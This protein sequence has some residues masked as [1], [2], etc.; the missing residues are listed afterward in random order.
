MARGSESG[1]FA[2]KTFTVTK[3]PA[4]RAEKL[5][6]RLQGI[7]PPVVAKV[8][9][10]LDG[11]DISKGLSTAKMDLGS[12]LQDVGC[13]AELLAEK[14]TP[15]EFSK[16]RQDLAEF[17]QVSDGEKTVPMKTAIDAGWFDGEIMALMWFV[18]FALKVNFRDFWDALAAR[19]SLLAAKGSPS[20]ST[21]ENPGPTGG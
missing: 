8:A 9:R 16:L 6:W 1:E 20:L 5:Y 7:L 4:A 14:M 10:A 13:A 11:V 17:T 18:G 19:A 12:V 15:D 21:S 3:L 2:G